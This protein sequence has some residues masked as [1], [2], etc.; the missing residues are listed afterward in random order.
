[1]NWSLQGWAF[2][3]MLILTKTREPSLPQ[4]CACVVCNVRYSIFILVG[5][6]CYGRTKIKKSR[7]HNCLG[8]GQFLL[9]KA[10]KKMKP[11]FALSSLRGIVNLF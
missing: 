7:H 5:F 3:M 6:S 1:M 2:Q 8:Q 9:A 4:Q 11:S 10:M